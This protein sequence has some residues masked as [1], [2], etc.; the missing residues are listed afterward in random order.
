MVSR[1]ELPT[2]PESSSNHWKSFGL[3]REG[4]QRFGKV[5]F[6]PHLPAAFEAN[7]AILNQLISTFIIQGDVVICR[8]RGEQTQS[9]VLAV[10]GTIGNEMVS[11]G[12]TLSIDDPERDEKVEFDPQA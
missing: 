3:T 7:I 9:P 8:Y 4:E 10:A 11:A 2:S 12:S 5:I 1:P 6:G